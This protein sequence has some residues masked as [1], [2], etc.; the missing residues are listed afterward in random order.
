[1]SAAVFLYLFKIVLWNGSSL[2]Q[3][4]SQAQLT[5][6][7][8]MEGLVEDDCGHDPGQPHGHRDRHQATDV[9]SLTVIVPAKKSQFRDTLVTLEV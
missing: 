4:F 3:V 6:T 9:L 7:R 2:S 8:L 1:M 5:D